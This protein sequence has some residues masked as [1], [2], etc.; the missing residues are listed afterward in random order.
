M[1]IKKRNKRGLDS[2][3][4]RFIDFSK[5][6]PEFFNISFMPEQFT[7]GKNVFK[8]RPNTTHIDTK[9]KIN[10]EIIDSNGKPIYHD[11]L[12]YKESDGSL[13]ATVYIYEETPPVDC[14]I[15]FVATSKYDERLKKLPSSE[16]KENNF[17]YQH[18][19]YVD[20]EKKNDSEVIYI[21]PPSA[22]IKE[23][24]F[25]VVEE[26]FEPFS[27]TYS[28]SAT[29]SYYLKDGIPYLYAGNQAFV[30]PLIDGILKFPS[31]GNNYFPSG[32]IYTC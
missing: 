16:V 20:P 3:S 28:Y 10:I 26:S 27:K 12:P 11:V 9:K 13:V 17:K 22:S 19:I 32:T 14:I 24:Q 23:R 21:Q 2:L 18:K 15:T 25:S 4:T 5:N 7:S 8:F 6:S 29:G 30:K 1:L 31:L